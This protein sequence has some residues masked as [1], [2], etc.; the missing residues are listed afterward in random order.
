[1]LSRIIVP[2]FESSTNL[3]KFV[4]PP[5][6]ETKKPYQ[7]ESTFLPTTHFFLPIDPHHNLSGTLQ[8]PGALQR[9]E[10]SQPMEGKDSFQQPL[11][12]V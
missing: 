8:G 11:L 9:L 6:P 5:P 12:S 3:P 4:F 7:F 2:C 10:T 1:M